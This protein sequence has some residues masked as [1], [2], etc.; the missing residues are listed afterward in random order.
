MMIRLKIAEIDIVIDETKEE[1]D[2][3]Y[4]KASKKQKELCKKGKQIKE[5][6]LLDYTKSEL[7]N[8]T[9]NKK[10]TRKRVLVRIKIERD[11]LHQFKYITNYIG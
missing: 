11:Q 8:K 7:A 3:T 4:L 1:V 9:E 2:T 5:E 6:E 10:K